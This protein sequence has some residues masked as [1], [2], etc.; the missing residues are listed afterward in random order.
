M[1]EEVYWSLTS[2][3][4][5]ASD[6]VLS[7]A[8]S[9]SSP[10]ASLAFWCGGLGLV[11]SAATASTT[12]LSYPSSPRTSLV[13]VG[14]GGAVVEHQRAGGRL[15]FACPAGELEGLEEKVGLCHCTP[16]PLHPSTPALLHLCHPLPRTLA[17]LAQVR[18]GWGEQ[19]VLTSLVSLDT[20][21]K[22]TVQVGASPR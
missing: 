6:P 15:A 22:A 1:N 13:L 18:A 11:P 8:I 5:P 3:P 16:A 9:C 14:T 4:Q 7:V 10:A 12:C 2:R 21:G 20:P 19:A 17:P